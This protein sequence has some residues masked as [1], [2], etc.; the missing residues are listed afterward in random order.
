MSLSTIFQLHRG[1]Q[2]SWWRKLEYP[3]KTTYLSQV[4]DKTLSSGMNS[5]V[6]G[7]M[8]QAIS[9]VNCIYNSE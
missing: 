2:F 8:Q 4:T 1:G 3:E 9:M 7:Y 5:N 6:I